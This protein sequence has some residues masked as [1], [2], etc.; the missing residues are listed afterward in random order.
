MV[1]PDS[2]RVPRVPRYSGRYPRRLL[3][4][5]YRTITFY[6]EPFQTLHLYNSFVTPRGFR[7][8]LQQH[9]TTPDMQRARAY[10]CRVWAIPISLA[11]TLGIEFLSLP[12]GTE[13]FHFPSFASPN[14]CIQ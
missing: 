10:T 3:H 11:A 12:E 4:F 7:T 13:M 1:L 8:N 9:P 5:D 6:G 14:L 2:R